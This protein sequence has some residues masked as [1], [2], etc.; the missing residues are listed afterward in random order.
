MNIIETRELH[1]VYEGVVPVHAV[2]GVDLQD[3]KQRMNKKQQENVNSVHGN[4]IFNS[5]VTITGQ[6]VCNQSVNNIVCTFC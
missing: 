4:K 3:L 2:N 6:L 5:N 1:K